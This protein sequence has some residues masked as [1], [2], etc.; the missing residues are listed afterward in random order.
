MREGGWRITLTDGTLICVEM[1]SYRGVLEKPLQLL[2]E[3]GQP[4]RVPQPSTNSNPAFKV[5]DPCIA[6]VGGGRA[7]RQNLGKTFIPWANLGE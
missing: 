2:I 7:A 3:G 4:I 6:A 1:L 5:S